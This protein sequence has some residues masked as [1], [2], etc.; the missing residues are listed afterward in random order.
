MSTHQR[1]CPSSCS[2]AIHHTILHRDTALRQ[3]PRGVMEWHAGCTC[4]GGMDLQ[5]H[6]LLKY[7]NVLTQRSTFNVSLAAEAKKNQLHP[8]ISAANTLWQAYNWK[9]NEM[10]A[11]YGMQTLNKWRLVATTGLLTLTF[12]RGEAF[13][14]TIFFQVL[15]YF[16]HM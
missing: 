2:A 14:I 12:I 3:R 8:F 1:C 4:A 11:Y 15:W 9:M 7:A 16:S 5:L 13:V 10:S 6:Y